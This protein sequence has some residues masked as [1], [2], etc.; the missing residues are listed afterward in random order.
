MLS[1]LGSG[2]QVH[3]SARKTSVCHQQVSSCVGVGNEPAEWCAALGPKRREVLRTKH[4]VLVKPQEDMACVGAVEVAHQ[5]QGSFS[6]DPDRRHVIACSSRGLQESTEE[7]IFSCAAGGRPCAKASPMTTSGR[8]SQVVASSLGALGSSIFVSATC[9]S[10]LQAIS[11][12]R[13]FI[14]SKKDQEIAVVG[15]DFS[16]TPFIIGSLKA[17]GVYAKQPASL[18]VPYQP[19]DDSN[20]GMMLGEGSMSTIVC[21]SP[22]G[23][24]AEI[25]GAVSLT[26]PS[27]S[28]GL[29]CEFVSSVL[30]TLLLE[31]GVLASDINVYLAHGSGTA[32]GDSVEEEAVIS[33]FGSLVNLSVETYKSLFGHLLGCSGLANILMY[34]AQRQTMGMAKGRVD[35]VAVCLSLGFGGQ[36]TAVCLRYL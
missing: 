8:L 20:H 22:E 30:R 21:G 4:A 26:E 23:A 24:F 19:W 34:E 14:R 3:G 17:L 31:S 15:S 36:A 18:E 11:Q 5:I 9:A 13:C 10:S 33:V 2:W 32:K 12:A 7:H 6:V 29:S 16:V 1:G 35:T 25:L 28:T 27:T